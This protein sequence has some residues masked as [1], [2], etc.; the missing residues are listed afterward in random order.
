MNVVAELFTLGAVLALVS[1]TSGQ[2]D[3]VSITKVDYTIPI[4]VKNIYIYQG[5]LAP[6]ILTEGAPYT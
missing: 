6:N 2:N 5:P 1:S 3:V 4:F